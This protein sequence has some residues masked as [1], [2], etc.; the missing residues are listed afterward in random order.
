MI[1]L[2]WSIRDVI[3]LQTHLRDLVPSAI[4]ISFMPLGVGGGLTADY[5]PYYNHSVS[6]LLEKR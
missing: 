5:A 3:R 1:M 4:R 6:M 2:A